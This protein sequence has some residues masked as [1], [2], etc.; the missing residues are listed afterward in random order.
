MVLPKVQGRGNRQCGQG[1]SVVGGFD[2]WRGLFFPFFF[3]LL[4][5][6]FFF[7]FFFSFLFR[8]YVG[9]LSF[10]VIIGINFCWRS[11]LGSAPGFDS[12]HLTFF[13]HTHNSTSHFFWP[14]F[15][16]PPERSARYVF[17]VMEQPA[18]ARSILTLGQCFYSLPFFPSYSFLA[19]HQPYFGG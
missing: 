12:A 18:H 10:Y 9:G 19:D 15:F 2:F 14:D 7:F 6:F 5:S 1:G 4:F 11:G 13:Y 3:S 8:S 17:S 16:N